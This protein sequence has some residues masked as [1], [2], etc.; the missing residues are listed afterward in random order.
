MSEKN[1]LKISEK[2]EIKID[3]YKNLY[4]GKGHAV[5]VLCVRTLS[6]TIIDYTDTVSP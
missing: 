2:Y 1:K 3:G 6:S 5:C 4:E